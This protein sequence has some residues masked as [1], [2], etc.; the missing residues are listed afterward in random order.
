LGQPVSRSLNAAGFQVRI[1]TRDHQ[2]ARDLFDD[3][4]QIVAGDMLDESDLTTAL[5][6]CYGVHISLPDAVEQQATEQIARIAPQHGVKRITYISGASVSEGTRWFPMVDAKFRAEAAIRKAGIPYTIL[7]PTWLMESLP[8]FVVD[9][10]AS[11]LGKQPTPYHW[12]A[13]DDLGQMVSTAYQQETGA[14][15]RVIVFGPEAILMKE[16]LGRYC[17]MFHPEIKQ[18]S[19]TP[20]WLVRIL[21]TLTRDSALKSATAMM[22]YFEKVGESIARPEADGDLGKPTTTLDQWL[23]IRKA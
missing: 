7:C 9:G 18:V 4:F 5:E 16:A 19:T 23:E 6:G 13:A 2:K 10:R 12:L 14:S 20:F 21:A 11:T 8:L 3:S 1:M 17:A 15:K 22:A